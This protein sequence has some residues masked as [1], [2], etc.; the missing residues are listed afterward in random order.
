MVEN[1]EL[2]GQSRM[3]LDRSDEVSGPETFRIVIKLGVDVPC[4]SQHEADRLA[5]RLSENVTWGG[6]LEN[7]DPDDYDI[8]FEAL[9]I[10]AVADSGADVIATDV[11]TEM[12]KFWWKVPPGVRYVKKGAAHSKVWVNESAT[13]RFEVQGLAP[14]L[15]YGSGVDVKNQPQDQETLVPSTRFFDDDEGPFIPWTRRVEVVG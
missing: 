10:V 4:E 12:W 14:R 9:P 7:V 13:E 6:Y 1:V 3:D 15:M 2:V 11:V 5:E 8:D